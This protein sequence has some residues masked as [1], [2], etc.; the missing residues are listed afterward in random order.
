VDCVELNLEAS[1]NARDFH[2]RIIGPA[3]RIVPDWVA[4]LG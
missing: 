2:R 3:S 1:V 4:S